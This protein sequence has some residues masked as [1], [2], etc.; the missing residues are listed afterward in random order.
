MNEQTLRNC[1]QLISNRDKIKSVFSWDG[2]LMHLA[3]AGVYAS[4]GA[5]V[6][7]AA[8]E[9]CKAL[10]KRKVG[11]LSNFRGMV[12]SPIASMIAVSDNPEQ[13]LD[14][15]LKAYE[16]LK[17]D[18]YSS[19]YLP[20][21]AMII[22]QKAESYDYERIASRT[23]AIYKMM[24]AEHP[25]LTSGEDSS[26]CAMMALS[27]KTDA[28]LIADAEKC[29]YILKEYFFSANAVQA[30]S[31]VLALCDGTPEEK[32]TKTMDLFKRLKA[33]GHKYGTE[34]ELPTLGV[35]AMAGEDFDTIVR[36]MIEIDEWLSRQKGF[37]F[38]GG[39][40][41]KQR[42]MY[43]GMLVQ[44]EFINDD[45]MHTSIVGSTIALVLAQEAAICAAIGASAAAAAAS[46]SG[47]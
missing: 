4:R 29:Y 44:K 43:A 33:A 12:Q 37:G 16:L 24:K 10:I 30:L 27:E 17:K 3:C 32:C 28:E 26:Y 35:L 20:L 9:E 8:L 19:T 5:D 13:T 23:H 41:A 47:S 40:T 25:F 42:L 21:A 18:F 38:W 1:G 7:V 2:G 36:E 14:N 15:G 34:H 39:V 46:N 11:L 31:H 6:D 45:A 22:A